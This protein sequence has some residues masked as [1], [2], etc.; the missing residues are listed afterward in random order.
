[1]VVNLSSMCEVIV[2][3]P[4]QKRRK[5]GKR[6]RGGRRE[7]GEKREGKGRRGQFWCL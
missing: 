2:Q 1:M 5:A 6:K 7:E 4:T 3:S